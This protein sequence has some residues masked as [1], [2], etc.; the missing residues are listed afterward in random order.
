VLV[1]IGLASYVFTREVNKPFWLNQS[2]DGMWLILKIW[3]IVFNN[4]IVPLEI[5]LRHFQNNLFYKF[6]TFFKN[7]VLYFLIPV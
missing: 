2:Y 4:F 6:E 5:I 3:L 7:Q 1:M